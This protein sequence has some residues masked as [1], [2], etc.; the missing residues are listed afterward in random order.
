MKRFLSTVLC[1]CLLLSLFGCGES[2]E[3]ESGDAVKS[4]SVGYGQADISPRVSVY[5][6]GYGE[7]VSERMSTG[8][9]EPLMLNCIAF[10]DEEDNTIL[11]MSLDLLLSFKAFAKPI[12]EQVAEA[13]GVPFDQV[14]LHCTHNHC[15]P[16]PGDVLYSKLVQ[17][18][19]VE[20]ATAAMADR[21]PATMS[22]GFSRHDKINFVRHYLLADG[23]YMGEGVGSVP[24]SQLV[25]HT[26]AP[27]NLLQVV[28]FD[29]EGGKP[30]V[31]INWQGHPMGSS[32]NPHTV[33]TS[34]YPG[35]LRT[36]VEKEMDCHSLF[37]LGGSGNM[38]NSSQIR[39]E[40]QYDDYIALGK[41]LGEK[42]IETMATLEP[43][44]TGKLHI[45][46]KDYSYT[47]ATVPLYAFSVGDLAFVTAPFEIFST[48]AVAVRDASQFKM[49]FYASCSNESH[50]YL[51]TPKSYE[52]FAYESGSNPMGVAEEVQEAL[53][54]LIGEVFTATGNAP[55]QW[56]EGYHTTEF[57]PV[58]DGLE[59]IN[60]AAGDKTAY[61][62]VKNGFCQV[63]LLVNG[64]VKVKLAL[65][66]DVAKQ[67]LEKDKMKLLFNEQN[68]IVGIAE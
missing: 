50:G 37:V 59:Y 51:A 48:N 39:E 17:E 66:E 63:Q 32:P 13:T 6:R 44:E 34:N 67:V 9:A 1:V 25:G 20:A 26:D 29:R 8:V 49:T 43:A 5:L 22:T 52:Y 62:V 3:K 12:R 56:K 33:A 42:V 60:L 58:S 54:Q 16:D 46:K 24:R 21:K 36:T 28:K 18:A 55:A 41:A 10:T 57:V 65:N 14:M 68:V 31:L 64:K 35:F 19:A 45:A 61:T 7:P 38:N 47:K 15:G 2:G 53:T 40:N 23:S 4:F 11:F 30:V 27:D